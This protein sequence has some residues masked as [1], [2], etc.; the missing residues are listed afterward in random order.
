MLPLAGS[1]PVRWRIADGLVPYE[2]AVATMERE[3]AAIAEG[4]AD[5]LV[6]LVE[7]PPLS[8]SEGAVLTAPV[9]N[10]IINIGWQ[11]P[12]IGKDD[13]ATYAADVFSYIIQQP[14]SRF[15]R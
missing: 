12:S 7:H 4:R 11:G 2:E 5:E 1:P 3:V 8:G 14:D 6:W 15:Q 13:A 10:V 9:S